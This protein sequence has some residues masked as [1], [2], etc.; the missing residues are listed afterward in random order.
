MMFILRKTYSRR[1][2]HD[3][4]GGQRQGGCSTPANHNIIFLFTG[5]QGKKYGYKD[6]W[7]EN[8]IFLLT[9]EGQRGDMT[10]SRGNSAIRDHVIKGKDLHLFEYVQSGLVKYQGQMVCTGNQNQR[11]EDV[12]GNERKII[13]FEL[14]PIEHFNVEANDSEEIY[15]EKLHDLDL[16][17][18]RQRA[19]ASS[20]TSRTPI[21]RQTQAR[22]RSI[23]IKVYILKRADGV[24]EA[25]GANAPFITESGKLYLEPHHITR[26][27][28]GGP[29]HPKWII[30]LCPNCH[31][32]AHYGNNKEKFKDKL[33]RIV[34][35]KEDKIT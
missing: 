24:C 13:V 18:L 1:T 3:Q 19:L 21:E 8:G 6:E 25:C 14:S 2:L 23:A 31:R 26:L 20:T 12:N 29:D 4:Y 30:G 32:K 33:T 17:I 22:Y 35:E 7:T 27:S 11:G 34:H 9:G 10:F 16:N 28:D 15:E 5:K